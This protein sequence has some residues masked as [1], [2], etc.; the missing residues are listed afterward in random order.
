VISINES[1]QS[2]ELDA[3]AYAF[4]ISLAS[5]TIL[6][7]DITSKELPT[8][9]GAFFNNVTLSPSLLVN[10]TVAVIEL[11]DVLANVNPTKTAVVELG[12]VYIV[13]TPE[14]IPTFNFVFALNVLAIIFPI[15]EQLT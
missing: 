12:T 15:Q 13:L 14:E 4:N 10:V 2:I 11:E 3:L 9:I 7:P 6:F 8:G 5:I 1:V